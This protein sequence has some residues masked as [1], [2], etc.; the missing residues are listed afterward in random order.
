MS[1]TD[2]KRGMDELEQR[3]KQLA[4]TEVRVGVLQPTPTEDGES[5]VVVVAAAHEHGTRHVPQRSF[6]GRTVDG[7]R[8]R[9][10]ALQAQAIDHVLAGE[11]DVEQAAGAV[12]AKV[13]SMIRDTIRSSVPPP[14]DPATVKAKGGNSRTLIE[15]GQLLRSITF[16]VGE[17][18]AGG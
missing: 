13:A 1:V 16:E 5:T 10:A 15:S 9:I 7:E 17:E 8:E 14:L 18:A 11:L 6:I 12:G 4:R 2:D 3:L